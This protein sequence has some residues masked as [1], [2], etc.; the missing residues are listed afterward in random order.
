MQLSGEFTTPR[1]PEEVYALL[2]DPSQF[3]PLF[4]EFQSMTVQDPTHFTMKVG[5]AVGNIR[6]SVEIEME[7]AEASRPLRVLYKGQGTAVGSPFT[8]RTGFDLSPG[9]EGTRVA[10]QGEANVSGNLAL[11]AGSMLDPLG[12]QNIQ[13][14]ID[15]LQKAL[16]EPAPKP[17]ADEPTVP[18]P[19]NLL[20]EQTSEPAN[21][22][23]G[24]EMPTAKAPEPIVDEPASE[25]SPDI[26]NH[27]ETSE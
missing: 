26:A 23:A 1:S 18:I 21:G 19:Q 8:V 17:I 22:E 3:G 6:G 20:A 15:G 16:A 24:N 7:L 9:D 14:L 5:V 12:R 13:K 2:S 4:P 27:N 11:M 25:R 10:W